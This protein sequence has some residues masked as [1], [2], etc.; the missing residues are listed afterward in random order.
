ML[1][2]WKVRNILRKG[3]KVIYVD[4]VIVEKEMEDRCICLR[5]V[6]NGRFNG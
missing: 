4:E 1:Y 5:L 3:K 2:F 6:V